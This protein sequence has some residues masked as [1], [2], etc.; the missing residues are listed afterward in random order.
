MRTCSPPNAAILGRMAN[1]M[2][3]ASLSKAAAAA[4]K[5]NALNA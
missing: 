2:E 3:W 4:L 1:L 5:D